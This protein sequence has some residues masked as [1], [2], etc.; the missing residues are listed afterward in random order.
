[1]SED[2]SVALTYSNI[3]LGVRAGDFPVTLAGVVSFDDYLQ[4][5]Q[6]RDL[7]HKRTLM[8]RQNSL[9][10]LQ[11]VFDDVSPYL[12]AHETALVYR[13]SR[14]CEEIEQKYLMLLHILTK[15]QLATISGRIARLTIRALSGY[16]QRTSSWELKPF[17]KPFLEKVM[18]YASR[19]QNL[20]LA[21]SSKDERLLEI[22]GILATI[23]YRRLKSAN[24]SYVTTEIRNHP[25]SFIQILKITWNCVP[26]EQYDSYSVGPPAL[27]IRKPDLTGAEY[28]YLSK[29]L[30]LSFAPKAKFCRG[31]QDSAQI[32]PCVHAVPS[33]PFGQFMGGSASEQCPSCRGEYECPQCLYKTPLCDGYTALCGDV[34]FAGNICCGLFALYVTRFGTDLKVGTAIYSNILGRLLEQ[35]AGLALVVYPITGIMNAHVLEKNV[36]DYLNTKLNDLWTFKIRKTFTRAP[37]RSEILYDFINSWHRNDDPLLLQVRKLLDDFSLHSSSGVTR[38][39]EANMVTCDFLPNYVQPPHDLQSRYLRPVPSFNSM[40]GRVVGYRGSFVFLDSGQV[41]DFK[42]LDGCVVRGTV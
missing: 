6:E 23:E 4:E 14:I 8:Q 15:T 5:L 9:Y 30:E 13:S 17:S 21:K 36:K 11:S 18:R 1:M 7:P 16:N 35:G 26:I 2:Y 39:A 19:P 22:A 31:R 27:V 34:E 29:D 42:E 38:I 12:T 25:K 10:A 20:V 3:Q 37:P 40:N 28:V 32:I 41:A 33:N 24:G